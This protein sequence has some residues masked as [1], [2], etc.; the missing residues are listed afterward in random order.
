M[1]LPLMLRVGRQRWGARLAET[2]VNGDMDGDM[3]ENENWGVHG[4]KNVVVNGDVEVRV[5]INMSSKD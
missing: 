4:D 2:D 3:N 5:G 1:M